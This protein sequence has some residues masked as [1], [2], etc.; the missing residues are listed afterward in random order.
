[1]MYGLQLPVHHVIYPVVALIDLHIAW[2]WLVKA[3]IADY[4]G[5]FLEAVKDANAYPCGNR[6]AYGSSPS[7]K[8]CTFTGLPYTLRMISFHSLLLAPPPNKVSSSTLNPFSS[9]T[10]RM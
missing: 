3:L 9:K 5:S 6:R 4:P 7:R 10:S 2:T 8:L 1:M